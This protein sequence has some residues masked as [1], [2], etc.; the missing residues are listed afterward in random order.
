MEVI[1]RIL[2]FTEEEKRRVGIKTSGWGLL[3]GSTNKS[4]SE[5][6]D[7]TLTDMWVDF[8]LKEVETDQQKR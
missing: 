2:N 6:K 3:S 1:A 7:S 4:T 5:D 8:L